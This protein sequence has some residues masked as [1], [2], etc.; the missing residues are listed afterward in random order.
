[1]S[2]ICGC[3]NVTH[4]I[5][6]SCTGHYLVACLTLIKGDLSLTPMG[7]DREEGEDE[8]EAER[9]GVIAMS[10]CMRLTCTQCG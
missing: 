8:E 6:D 9:E 4:S 2:Y 3:N 7:S 5:D 1:M 10:Y